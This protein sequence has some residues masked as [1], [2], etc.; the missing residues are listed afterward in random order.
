VPVWARPV[1][2]MAM[3]DT[4]HA[5]LVRVASD[6]VSN[7]V[8]SPFE[9]E[10]LV[11]SPS[12]ETRTL[13]GSTSSG[14]RSRSSSGGSVDHNPHTSLTH[15]VNREVGRQCTT[16]QTA[17]AV[18]VGSVVLACPSVTSTHG[19]AV[20]SG[21]SGIHP[22]PTPILSPDRVYI[23]TIPGRWSLLDALGD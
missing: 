9:D 7:V 20:P 21:D 10:G 8:V 2:E 14:S 1:R 17:L 12:E 11:R 13:S 5:A 6:T 19:A 18:G 3:G 22:A 4:G 23:H 15:V 16:T